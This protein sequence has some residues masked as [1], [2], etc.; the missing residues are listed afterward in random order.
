[1]AYYKFTAST[2][3]ILDRDATIPSNLLGLTD[4]V[5]ALLDQH[6]RPNPIGLEDVCFRRVVDVTVKSAWQD[7]GAIVSEVING[8][9]VD[10]VYT[11]IDQDVVGLRDTKK[12][13]VTTEYLNRAALPMVFNTIPIDVSTDG[14]ADI[15]GVRDSFVDGTLVGTK[16]YITRGKSKLDL[17]AAISQ[18]LYAALIAH[19]SGLKEAERA[20]YDA[21]DLLITAQ[22][23]Y[24]YDITTGW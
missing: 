16:K 15:K 6:V 2:G 20:H 7:S 21:I 9:V 1:M 10:V 11:A 12:T 17:N 4:A 19:K 8:D 3:A 5:L 22:T 23:I 13:A 18:A 14:T 24:E